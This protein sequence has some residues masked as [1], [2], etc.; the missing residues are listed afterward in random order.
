[1]NH[2]TTFANSSKRSRIS[3]K[4]TGFVACLVAANLTLACQA[5][6]LTVP[7]TEAFATDAANWAI[8]PDGTQLATWNATGGPTNSTFISRAGSGP[9][10]GFGQFTSG[11]ILFRGQDAFDSSGDRFVGDWIAGGVGSFSVDVFHDHSSPLLFQVRLANAA[12]SPGAS[13]VDV[14]VSP[15]A[16]TTLT[17]PIVDSAAAFQT[18]GQLGNPPDAGA[19]SQIFSSIGNI[20]IGLAPGQVG[21]TGLASSVTLGMANPSVAAVP[22]PGA[23]AVIWAVAVAAGVAHLRRGRGRHAA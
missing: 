12:N 1:M 11:P 14:S 13:S 10:T 21:A 23:W 22:E 8:V 5:Q 6:S 16:W 4:P 15:G 2:D 3:I 9:D 20:Q 17:V 19:F 18:Y 7:Y